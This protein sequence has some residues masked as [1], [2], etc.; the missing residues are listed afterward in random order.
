[1]TQDYTDGD[2]YYKRTD[3]IK[4]YVSVIPFV[5]P[6]P[7]IN[8][9]IIYKYIH[10]TYINN[11]VSSSSHKIL[12]FHANHALHVERYVHVHLVINF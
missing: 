7:I 9:N 5:M 12:L 8:R 2:Y 6:E 4:L 1:M 10:Y 11:S 3:N